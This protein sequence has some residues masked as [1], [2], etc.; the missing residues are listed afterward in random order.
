MVCL[1]R[2]QLVHRVLPQVEWTGDNLSGTGVWNG[3]A[4][5][6]AWENRAI[7]SHGACLVALIVAGEKLGL[8]DGVDVKSKQLCCN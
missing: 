2:S 3:D 6:T 1:R 8:Y 4:C 5:L 7:D